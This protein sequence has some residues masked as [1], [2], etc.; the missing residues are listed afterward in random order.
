LLVTVLV[1][2]GCTDGSPQ[3]A[4]PVGSSQAGDS[5]A[6]DVVGSAT[7]NRALNIG[8]TLL[9]FD[10]QV[11][12][13]LGHDLA[14]IEFA[15]EQAQLRNIAACITSAGYV[16]DAEV[17]RGFQDQ[18]QSGGEIE[19]YLDLI[20]PPTG[21]EPSVA[22]EQ[23]KLPEFRE[24]AQRCWRETQDSSRSPSAQ[25]EEQLASISASLADRLTTDPRYI[26][27][28]EAAMGCLAERGY[29]GDPSAGIND[30]LV[31]AGEVHASFV[32]GR[33]GRAE[34]ER[35]L[36]LIAAQVTVSR[37]IIDD[38]FADLRSTEFALLT[39]IQ[40][41]WVDANSGVI[42]GFA[43]QVRTEVATLEEFMPDDE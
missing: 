26:D 43:E 9:P 15:F 39:D 35:E 5:V 16:A 6:V 38:C 18:E 14:T 13:T 36:E 40:Q 20:N 24:L 7:P 34:A 42:A 37:S 12:Q 33:L 23:W 21:S 10:E 30:A 11:R 31:S 1:G 19:A 28:N 2:S 41:A 27:A 22:K 32:D 17:M 29:P 25:L 3:N 4:G 8:R